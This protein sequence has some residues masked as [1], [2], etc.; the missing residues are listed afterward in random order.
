MLI[1]TGDCSLNDWGLS[2]LSYVDIP[3]TDEI[4]LLTSSGTKTGTIADKIN[5]HIDDMLKFIQ[6]IEQREREPI[7]LFLEDI[8]IGPNPKVTIKLAKN[9][10]IIEY[11]FS[12]PASRVKKVFTVPKK[13]WS[14]VLPGTSKKA[15]KI[16]VTVNMIR[17]YNVSKMEITEHEGDAL[18]LMFFVQAMYGVLMHGMD[19]KMALEKKEKIVSWILREVAAKHPSFLFHPKKGKKTM[20]TKWQFP[21]EPVPMTIKKAVVKVLYSSLWRKRLYRFIFE[22]K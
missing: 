4:P 1:V 21:D 13:T 22:I 6:Q 15:D 9:L 10:G 2:A 7:I 3:G 8:F 20:K 12:D 14:G 17:H 19:Y 18:G 16:N 5:R 11:L